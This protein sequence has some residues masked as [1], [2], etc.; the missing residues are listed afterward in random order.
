MDQPAECL[1]S[2]RIEV[3]LSSCVCHTRL[4]K[5]YGTRRRT[6]SKHVRQ[7]QKQAKRVAAHPTDAHCGPQKA[8]RRTGLYAT[9]DQPFSWSCARLSNDVFG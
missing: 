6:T 1:F 5:P 9:H 4:C 8:E 2:L 7:G 3:G